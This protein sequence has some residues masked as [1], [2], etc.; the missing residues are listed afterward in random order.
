MV[1]NSKKI[2]RFHTKQPAQQQRPWNLIQRFM[3]IFKSNF[4]IENIGVNLQLV[5]IRPI[6][7]QKLRAIPA[8]FRVNR[9]IKVIRG[10]LELWKNGKFAKI[11]KLHMMIKNY[12]NLKIEFELSY[13]LI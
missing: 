13:F 10:H 11:E 6:V 8:D 5:K 9:A 12:Q 7:R 2:G 1:K 4:S 3:I